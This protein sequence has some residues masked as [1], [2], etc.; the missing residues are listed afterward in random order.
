HEGDGLV[1]RRQLELLGDGVAVA[2]PPLQTAQAV[3]DLVVGERGH[4][5]LL[6]RVVVDIALVRVIGFDVVLELPLV[7]EPQVAVG[8]LANHGHSSSRCRR[9]PPRLGRYDRRR[10]PGR[11]ERLTALDLDGAS[12]V[13][14]AAPDA[15]LDALAVLTSMRRWAAGRAERLGDGAVDGRGLRM[16]IWF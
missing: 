13:R 7:L 14:G 16:E 5:L 1:E 4:G 15:V 11:A 12:R 10:R 8:T 2:V 9:L 3:L 6:Y